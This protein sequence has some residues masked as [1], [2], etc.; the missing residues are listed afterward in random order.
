MHSL[1]R[2]IHPGPRFA[3]AV[4][5]LAAGALPGQAQ[6]DVPSDGI[7]GDLVLSA[8]TTIDL[9]QAITGQ[10]DTPAA[11]PGKGVYDP[12]KWA[13]VFRYRSVT[14]NPGA[15]VSFKNHPSRAPVV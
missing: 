10:W 15:T 2:S 3:L 9:S 11:V 12:A 14:T 5:L 8:A 6:L 13:V 7:D 1:T 4:L